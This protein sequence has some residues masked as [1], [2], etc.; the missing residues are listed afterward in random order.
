MIHNVNK[1][2]NSQ[3]EDKIVIETLLIFYKDTKKEIVSV[4]LFDSF[5]DLVHSV[6]DFALNKLTFLQ[7]SLGKHDL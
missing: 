5:L 4:L 1:T 6:L 3:F 2:L 7:C